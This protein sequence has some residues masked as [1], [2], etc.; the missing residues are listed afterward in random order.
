MFAYFLQNSI[1]FNSYHISVTVKDKYYNV[2]KLYI[3]VWAYKVRL[4]SDSSAKAK[5]VQVNE[6]G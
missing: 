2:H 6:Y 1:F 5:S 3:P 4:Y